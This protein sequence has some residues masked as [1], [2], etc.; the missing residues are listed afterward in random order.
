MVLDNNSNDNGGVVLRTNVD[1]IQEFKLQTNTYS[2]EF[3][4]QRGR[5]RE[6]D[7]KVGNEPVSRQ[8]V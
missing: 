3:G 6:C 1:A 2:A 7:H 5:C 4:A 8:R